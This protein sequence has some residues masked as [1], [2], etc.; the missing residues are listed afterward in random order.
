MRKILIVEDEEEL[1]ALLHTTL[2]KEYEVIDAE[3][4]QQGLEVALKEHPDIILLDIK[5]P[6]MGGWEM[7]DELRKDDYGKNA[8]IIMLT[9]L[10]ADKRAIGHVVQEQPVAYWVKSNLKIL[11]IGDK[12]KS[13]LAA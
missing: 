8:K 5:M 4:G 12:I 2:E 7:L 11:D 10:D 3:D 13:V 1:L 9:N 6:K